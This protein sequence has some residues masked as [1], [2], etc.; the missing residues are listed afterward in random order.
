M[1]ADAVSKFSTVI[2]RRYN[3]TEIGGRRIAA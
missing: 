1:T 2:D 3:K